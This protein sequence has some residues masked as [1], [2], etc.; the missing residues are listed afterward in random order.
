MTKKKALIWQLPLLIWFAL[1]MTGLCLPGFCLVEP[2]FQDDGIFFLLYLVAILSFILFERIGRWVLTIWLSLWLLT[3]LLSHEWYTVF[4]RGVM[5]SLDGKITAFSH[6]LQ[7][8][9]WPGRYVPDVYHT[10]LHLLILFALISLL[11]YLRHS[12]NEKEI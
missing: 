7:W 1:D 12:K 6:T 9:V 3:Q 10:I 5:G 11:R 2:A 8:G 4:G